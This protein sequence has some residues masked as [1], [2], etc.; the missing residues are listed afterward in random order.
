MKIRLLWSAAALAGVALVAGCSTQVPQSDP[1]YQKLD[2]LQQQVAHLQ[3]VVQGQGLMD[4]ASNQQQLEQQ[5]SDLQGQIQEL[6]HDLAQ[7][8]D[9]QQDVDKSFDQRLSALEQGASAVGIQA[10]VGAGGHKPATGAPQGGSGQGGAAAP[11][12][13]G[14]PSDYQA[15]RDAFNKLRNGDDAGAIAG[16]K[17]FIQKYPTSRFVPNAWYWMGEAHYVD[18]EYKEAIA[19]FQQV[20]T[21]FSNSAKASDAYL[22]VGYAQYALKDY[23][24][25]RQTFQAVIQRY[26]GTT[27]AD[28]ARQRL[29]QMGS[30]GQ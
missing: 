7:A 26:P 5:L 14:Q 27:A 2:A 13:G 15:Y 21:K 12:G 22:K 29:Q 17:A 30:Q 28:L 19:N 10:G 9:R 4:L 3:K 16:F 20:L 1:V 8:Q 24:S 11:S 6:Q 23:K 18:G 25:A